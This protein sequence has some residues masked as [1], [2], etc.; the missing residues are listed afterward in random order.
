MFISFNSNKNCSAAPAIV[1]GN[2]DHVREVNT[3][4][5]NV[6]T[7]DRGHADTKA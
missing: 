2:K 7:E 1:Y 3:V 6:N 5:F 4:A